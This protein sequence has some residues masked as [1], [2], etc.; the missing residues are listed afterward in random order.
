MESVAAA[1]AEFHPVELV[2]GLDTFRP[3]TSEVLEDHRIHHEIYRVPEHTWQAVTAARAEG[4]RVIAVGTTSVRALESVARHG[5]LSGETGLFI[6]PGYEFAVVDVIMTNF[7]MPRT[8]L[9]AMIEAF[10][11]R[12][13]RDL[14]RVAIER[15]YRFLSFGD[16]MWLEHP[17][18]PARHVDGDDGSG[19]DGGRSGDERHVGDYDPHRERR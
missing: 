6:T 2:V 19:I 9:L 4:R 14:Y 5:R 10:V 15:G 8:T 17:Q 13:W 16:A 1:G 18:D 3:V 7:H 11:G 12:R